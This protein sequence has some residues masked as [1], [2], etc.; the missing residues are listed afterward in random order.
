MPS[1]K[2]FGVT[3]IRKSGIIKINKLRSIINNNNKSVIFILA[4][5]QFE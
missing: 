2:T 4:W 5:G 3:Y 1:R